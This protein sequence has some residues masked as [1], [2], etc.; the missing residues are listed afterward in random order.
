[1]EDRVN[2]RELHT[3]LTAVIGVLIYFFGRKSMQGACKWD[4]FFVVVFYLYHFTQVFLP[5]LQFVC[6]LE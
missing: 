5:V 1:L 4:D 2:R 6:S 3:A